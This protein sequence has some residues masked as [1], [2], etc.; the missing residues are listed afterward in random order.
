[1]IPLSNR[2]L[3]DDHSSSAAR[4]AA[5]NATRREGLL[6]MTL[7]DSVDFTEDWLWYALAAVVGLALIRW[8]LGIVAQRARQQQR[9]RARR[10]DHLV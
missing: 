1:M 3:T 5:R 10:D 7:M 4:M 6:V 9:G 8:L 2:V